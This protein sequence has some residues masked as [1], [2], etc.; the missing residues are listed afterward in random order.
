AIAGSSPARSPGSISICST[1]HPACSSGRKRWAPTPIPPPRRPWR[2]WSATHSQGKAG[3]AAPG[4]G[5]VER[6]SGWCARTLV[7]VG[8]HA[9]AAA[10]A[11]A[12]QPEV[13]DED[14]MSAGRFLLALLAAAALPATAATYS[15]AFNGNGL[16]ANV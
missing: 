3:R 6:A 2:S 15:V 16:P 1:A 10:A 11:H 9:R 14:D 12:L 7:R 4:E 5:A 8:E 13:P